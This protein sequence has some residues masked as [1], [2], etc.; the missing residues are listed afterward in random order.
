M[1]ID[2]GVVDTTGRHSVFVGNFSKEMIAVFGHIGEDLFVDRAAASQIGRPSL[3]TLTFGL[4]L[5]DPDLDGDLDLF[6]ANGHVQQEIAVTQDGITYKQSPHLFV[7]NGF[8][9]FH[10]AAP[11]LGGVFQEPIVG[12]GAAYA[13]IDRD[14]D[15]DILVS[16]N[17]GGAHLWRN[18]LEGNRNWLRVHLTGSNANQDALGTRI[19]LY[20]NTM[21]QER[22]IRGGSSFMAQHERVATW[23]LGMAQ[24][25]DSI[26]VF[27]P[28]GVV[29]TLTDVAPN[30]E[31]HL[32]EGDSRFSVVPLNQPAR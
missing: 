22:W 32:V 29:Q 14:G 10:D 25:A 2:T 11:E 28:D 4:F 6:A 9:R 24:K 12:R 30:Q 13:D 19:V 17:G 3:M 27:W 20:S 1:G 21:S 18:D 23:G 8:G 26:Q 16:E 15:L 5:F 7:N 31:I